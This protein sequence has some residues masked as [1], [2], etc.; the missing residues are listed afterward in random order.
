MSAGLANAREKATK[1]EY[2]V[3]GIPDG[4]DWL[5]SK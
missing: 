2:D 4:L 1:D 3:A 5:A